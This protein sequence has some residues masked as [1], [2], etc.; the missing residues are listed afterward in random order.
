MFF[1][2]KLKN[3]LIALAIV[4][5]AAVLLLT[6][7]GRRGKTAASNAAGFQTAELTPAGSAAP[8]APA[9][10]AAAGEPVP[11]TARTLIIDAGHGGADGG[12]S[13]ATQV[14]AD[15]NLD[16][17]L[18]MR[19]IAGLFGVAPVMTRESADIAYPDSAKTI[20]AKKVADQKQRVALINGTPDA[21][22]I[23]IHQNTFPSSSIV[24]GIQV[25]YAKTAGSEEFASALQ[26]ALRVSL[27]TGNRRVAMPIGGDIYLMK[28]VTCPA[29]LVEC[30]FLSNPED[31]AA[32]ATDTYRLKIAA[33]LWNT[34]LQCD[35]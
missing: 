30:G 25:F 13:S 16:I 14:E 4:V 6:L 12:S 15:I 5:L 29:V 1:T 9:V 11:K 33:V 23:S 19:A 2:F 31:D 26:E 10:S 28:N 3:L 24:R 21:L 32:L 7:S 34:Y 8:T 20:R 18:R 35:S 27:D 17:A 22:L